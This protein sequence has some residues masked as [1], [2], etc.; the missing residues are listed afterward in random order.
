MYITTSQQNTL[1]LADELRH[2]SL[3]FDSWEVFELYYLGK[4]K[5]WEDELSRLT[6][7]EHP[8]EIQFLCREIIAVKSMLG[9]MKLGI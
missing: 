5:V 1:S 6:I 8:I 9:R 2:N 7:L 3:P 4:L